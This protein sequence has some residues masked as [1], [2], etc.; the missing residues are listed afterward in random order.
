MHAK[1]A[2]C[3]A[4]VGF[5]FPGTRDNMLVKVPFFFAQV[6]AAILAAWTRYLRGERI[7]LWAPS[8]R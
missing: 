8:R 6:N 3:L 7:T 4:A 5:A 2:L 1:F